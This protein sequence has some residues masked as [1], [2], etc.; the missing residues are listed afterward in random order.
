M[1]CSRL[2]RTEWRVNVSGWKSYSV[3]H[4]HHAATR[5]IDNRPSERARLYRCARPSSP[6]EGPRKAIAQGFGVEGPVSGGRREWLRVSRE[7]GVV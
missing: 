5:N 7:T 6:L 1:I 4:A 3:Y 2:E